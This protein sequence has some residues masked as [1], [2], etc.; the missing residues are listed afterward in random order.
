MSNVEVHASHCC[1]RHWCKY[2]DDDCPVMNG[3]VD[4]I[5]FEACEMCEMERE[6]AQ[7]LPTDVL[8]AVL[9]AR[10]ALTETPVTSSF[11]MKGELQ[12]ITR[13]RY[14]SPW[15]VILDTT[16]DPPR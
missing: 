2:G 14:V 10:E 1:V 3:T 8:I 7:N 6:S 15:V 5:S 13:R 11:D 4:G 12:R 9:V 16:L